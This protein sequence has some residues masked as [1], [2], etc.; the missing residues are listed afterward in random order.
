MKIRGKKTPALKKKWRLWRAEGREHHR[1]KH[2]VGELRRRGA[3][4]LFVLLLAGCGKIPKVD[5]DYV[6]NTVDEWLDREGN[7]THAET[8]IVIVTPTTPAPVPS[9]TIPVPV[10]TTTIPNWPVPILTY[11][12]RGTWTN[13]VVIWAERRLIFLHDQKKLFRDVI[14]FKTG[15]DAFG[16]DNAIEECK[17][18]G[19]DWTHEKPMS[20][21]PDPAYCVVYARQKRP[22]ETG[23]VIRKLRTLKIRQATP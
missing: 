20:A 10:P 11:V 2:L 5:R 7:A 14:L 1:M 4:L 6:Y 23:Y 21:F 3:V 15:L 17:R 12:P 18:A 9:T 16:M 22:G 19:M 8:N 13:T